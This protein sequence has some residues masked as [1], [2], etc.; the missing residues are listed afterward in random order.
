MSDTLRVIAGQD[1]RVI[2]VKDHAIEH[3]EQG[4]W[5]IVVEAYE[6]EE[7]LDV[8]KRTRSNAGAIK[9]MASRVGAVADYRADI[10]AAGGERP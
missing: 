3:Y 5:D 10:I 4:G 1:P 6:D 9:K 7:I 8:I 2:A